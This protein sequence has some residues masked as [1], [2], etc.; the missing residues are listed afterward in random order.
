ML[1]LQLSFSP[2]NAGLCH[3]TSLEERLKMGKKDI[4]QRHYLNCTPPPTQVPKESEKSN[5]RL[6]C[7]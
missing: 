5:E 7:P 2:T 6:R 1:T 4:P 3:A